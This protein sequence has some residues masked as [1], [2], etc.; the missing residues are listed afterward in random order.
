MTYEYLDLLSQHLPQETKDT[1]EY[2][3]MFDILVKNR[4]RDIQNKE[5]NPVYYNIVCL[6]IDRNS[7]DENLPETRWWEGFDPRNLS[8]YE[9]TDSLTS[10]DLLEATTDQQGSDVS[11]V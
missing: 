3:R 1:T 4:T 2:V 7:S 6:S 9:G 11:S 10:W 5:H 8:L